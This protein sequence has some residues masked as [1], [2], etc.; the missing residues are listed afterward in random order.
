[1]SL[2]L[3]LCRGAYFSA[4]DFIHY[5]NP[6]FPRRQHAPNIQ[7]LK[8]EFLSWKPGPY[9]PCGLLGSHFRDRDGRASRDEL[10]AW[11]WVCRSL[12]RAQSS[13]VRYQLKVWSQTCKLQAG[14]PPQRRLSTGKHPV[15]TFRVYKIYIFT[16][17]TIEGK[18]QRCLQSL[19]DPPGIFILIKQTR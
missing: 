12:L 10:A 2:S 9:G 11:F 18:T 14:P 1:M 17:W 15:V 7:L 4:F 5:A 19:S 8:L 13:N 6:S 16:D 3:Y